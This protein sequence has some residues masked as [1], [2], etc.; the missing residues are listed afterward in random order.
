[1][2]KE[3]RASTARNCRE[4]GDSFHEPW[5]RVSPVVNPA[6]ARPDVPHRLLVVW[7]SVHAYSTFLVKLVADALNHAG[8]ERSCFGFFGVNKF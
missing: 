6:Y 2:P 3:E 5:P 8:A 7:A 4:P 1:V